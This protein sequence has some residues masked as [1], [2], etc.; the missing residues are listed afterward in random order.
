MGASWHLRKLSS[1]I[2]VSNQFA[3][4]DADK[5]VQGLN[6]KQVVRISAIVDMYQTARLL[7]VS[8]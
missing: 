8:R 2:S 3:Y 4:R 6:L 1:G 7:E 5:E